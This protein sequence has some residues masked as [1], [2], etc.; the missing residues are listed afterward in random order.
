MLRIVYITLCIYVCGFKKTVCLVLLCLWCLVLSPLLSSRSRLVLSCSVL[1][2]L[3]LYISSLVLCSLVL[4]YWS[5]LAVMSSLVLSCL[6]HVLFR[7]VSSRLAFF[8][9][10]SCFVFSY[11][12]LYMSCLVLS[13]TSLVLSCVILYLSCLLHVFYLFSLVLSSLVFL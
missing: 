13:R 12:I 5:C 10:L 6:V 3:I 7:L 4:L 11:L 1:S 8:F 2:Y 9:V